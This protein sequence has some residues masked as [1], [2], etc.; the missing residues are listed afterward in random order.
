MAILPWSIGGTSSS[1]A[2]NWQSGVV[3]CGTMRVSACKTPGSTRTRAPR[4]IIGSTSSWVQ[5]VNQMKMPGYTLVN[6]FVQFRPM[7]RVQFML[8]ANNLFDEVAFIEITTPSVPAN[9]IGLGRAANGRT[10]SL[11]ARFDF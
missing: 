8:N 3:C 10:I 1:F 11:S 6:A 9:G 4:S 5:D 2:G 7:D